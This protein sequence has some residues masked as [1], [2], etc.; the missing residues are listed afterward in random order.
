MVESGSS[1]QTKEIL[2]VWV[3]D[4]SISQLCILF[5]VEATQAVMG[6]VL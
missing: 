2:E 4:G 5:T 6:Q 3:R 1:P